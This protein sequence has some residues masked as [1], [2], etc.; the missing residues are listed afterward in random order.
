MSKCRQC[1]VE[2]LDET[3]RCPF[4]HSVLEHTIEVENMYPDVKLQTR[5]W[6]F[7]SKIYLFGAILLEAVFFG[8][9]Y[10]DK[11]RIGWS[12]VAGLLLLYGYLVIRL[13]ILGK[14]GHKLKIVLLSAVAIVMMVMSDFL[15]GYHG[16]S[17]NYGLPAIVILMDLGIIFLM[18]IN[19]RNWQSYLMWQILMILVSVML[20]VFE[21]VG[22]INAPYVAGAAI[23]CSVF[24]FLGTLI[25]G[26]RRARVELKRRF[27]IM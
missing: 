18:I 2:V 19:R 23:A 4:C 26:D 27:H 12:L 14:A 24:L 8:I 20:V 16:W 25:I 9:N 17:V 13:A 11:Y 3:E 5:K 6:V 22:I 7:L 10:V 21:I 15:I 1:K